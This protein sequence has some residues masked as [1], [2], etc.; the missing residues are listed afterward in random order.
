MSSSTTLA[1]KVSKSQMDRNETKILVRAYVLLSIVDGKSELLTQALHD[2]PGV[3][4]TD[5]LE[6]VPNFLM[7]VEASD[8]L[9]LAEL[10]MPAIAAADG[11]I[12]DISL[13]ITRDSSFPAA[14]SNV[15]DR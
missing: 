2:M 7:M 5:Y 12:E 9:K 14:G 8:R 6:G 10:L 15:N 11:F 4:I 3:A 1:T 13:L